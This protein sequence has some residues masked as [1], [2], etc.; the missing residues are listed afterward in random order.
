MIHIEQILAGTI[1]PLG[2]RATPSGIDKHPVAG[3]VRIGRDG[4]VCDA[5]G[6]RKHHGGP[7]KA[8][9]HYAL[10]HY[11]YWREA[12]GESDVLGR[13]GAFGEN[14]AT[15]GPV[16]TD[17]AV[18]DTFRLGSALIQVSQGRQP[19]WKLNLR[20][21]VP[22]MA[23]RL[24]SSGRTGWYYRVMEAGDAAAGDGLVLVDRL[25]PEWTI[26]RLWRALYVDTLNMPELA[27]MSRLDHLAEGWRRYAAKRSATGQVEDW[28]KRLTGADSGS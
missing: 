11:P 19:C 18:G 26:D 9:H 8:I 24:Q 16:E 7:E 5:Q 10:D 1:R 25:S 14:L 2:P 3:R 27:A 20:F 4:L 12:I 15:T 23:L 22:D 6:D 21:G 13:P 17:V 28:S